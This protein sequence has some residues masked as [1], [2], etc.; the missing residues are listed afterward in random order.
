M[1]YSKVRLAGL[2]YELPPRVVTSADIERR[3]APVYERLRLPEGRLEMMS[4]IRERRFWDNGARP[5]SVATLAGR[6]AIAASG[7]RTDQLGA[8]FHVSVCRDF[9]E[10]AT[11]N[12]DH[13]GLGLSPKTLLF[14][15]SN[16]CLG[17]LDG[18][19]TL[20]NMIEL[21]QAEAGVIVAGEMGE[22]LVER[23]IEWLLNDASVTR[24][25][26]KPAFASLTIGSGA[27]AIVLA[28]E[29]L[30]PDKPRLIGG[31]ARCSTADADLCVSTADTGFDS[32]TAPLMNTDSEA[33][34]KAGCAL[35]ADTWGDFLAATGWRGGEI[36]RSFTHQVGVAHRRALYDAIGLPIEKDFATLE[37]LGNVGSVSLPVTLAIGSERRPIAS[38]DKAALLGIG[39]GL[40]CMMLGL[41]W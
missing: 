40:N 38:G 5:S 28:H 6:K 23:T 11:A 27:A 41:E 36:T 7:L 17:A 18:M 37:F 14:D 8:L 22:T 15:I 2:G 30:A 9:L 39:S 24:Q 3:L 33:L 4:G 1:R 10:P 21:G 12:V 19:V 34:L 16:A 20:A 31:A 13:H 29:R 25:S 35:A 26:I 32:A